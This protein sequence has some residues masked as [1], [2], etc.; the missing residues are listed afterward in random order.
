MHIEI[1]VEDSSGKALLSHVLPRIIGSHGHPH[2]YHIHAYKG[3]GHIPKNLTGKL[4]PSKRV[5]LDRLPKVL[6]GYSRSEGIDAV[7]V[8]V[9]AD[10]RDCKAFLKE[11][12]TLA[13]Q[14][15]LPGTL[16]RLAIEEIEAFYLGDRAALLKAYPKAKKAV[17]SKY[18]QDMP[19]NTWELLADAVHPGGAAATRSSGA[20]PGDLKHEWA[21]KIGP[22]LNVE[23]NES[24]SF[25]KLRDGLRRIV[26]G[27]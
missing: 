7:V 23:A 13:Q 4:D 1:L 19:C 22:L 6:R 27:E 14:A 24:S 9:D 17:L 8:V 21:N 26:R 15:E 2:T 10:R 5:L 20:R 11:L 12:T 18:R 16:F 25:Q 3:V